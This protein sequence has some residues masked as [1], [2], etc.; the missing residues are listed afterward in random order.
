MSCEVDRATKNLIDQTLWRP[1]RGKSTVETDVYA[2]HQPTNDC[3]IQVQ[4]LFTSSERCLRVYV[5]LQLVTCLCGDESIS[6]TYL[7]RTAN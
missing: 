3:Q 5:T 2:S 7:K 4:L 6:L 1:I